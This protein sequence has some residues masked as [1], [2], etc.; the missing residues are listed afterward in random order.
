MGKTL[1]VAFQTL[2]KNQYLYDVNTGTVISDNGILGGAMRL[3]DSGASEDE[4]EE[5]LCKEYP[6]HLVHGVFRFIRRWRANYSGF[7]NSSTENKITEPKKELIQDEYDNGMTYL[8]V[9]NVTENCNFRCKYCYLTEEYDFTR[10]RTSNRMSFETAKKAMDQYFDYLR[11]LRKKIPNKKAGIT[12]YGGEPLLEIDLVRKIVAYCRENEPVPIILNMTSNGYLLTDEIMDFVVENE[13]HLAVSLDGS[14][15]NHDRNRV[16]TGEQGSHE[17]VVKNLMRFQEKYPDYGNIGIISVYD[18]KTDLVENERFFMEKKLPRIF[19]I[20]EV[21][22]TN[23]NY[24]DRFTKDDVRNFHEVHDK[25]MR[26]YIKA[27]QNNEEMS[28]YLQMLFEAPISL[29]V[30]R[31][32]HL[33]AKSALLPYTNTCIPGMKLSIRTDGK[34]DICERINSTFPIGDIENGLNLDAISG[35]IKQYNE[36]VTKECAECDSKN[37]CPLC[38][39]YTNGNGD[40][41]IREGFCENWRKLQREKVAVV[42]SILEKNPTAFDNLHNNLSSSFLFRV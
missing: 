39:A 33:D 19:F 40:F 3:L 1:T 18:T 13:I 42:Y 15:K 5:A 11:K 22:A 34:I 32:R 21:S 38:F 25:L 6:S 8:M 2:E 28:D 41:H 12:I 17:R 9:L 20:N 27:K 10:N 37:N 16:L 23:T 36:S 30:M 35:I 24:Y 4:A 26:K 7:G 31:L 14:M 29:T